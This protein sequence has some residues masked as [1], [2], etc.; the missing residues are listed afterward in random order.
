MTEQ[1]IEGKPDPAATG[2]RLPS[3]RGGLVPAGEG[4]RVRSA[5]LSLDGTYEPPHL[6]VDGEVDMSTLPTFSDALTRVLK[7]SSGDVWVDVEKLGFIDVG[8]LRALAAAA[9]QLGLQGRRLV[10]RSVSPHLA[11]LLV[12]VGWSQ[13]ASLLMLVRDESRSTS[14]RARSTFSPAS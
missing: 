1:T 13:I 8:G 9:C 7:H 6:V 3:S 12:L 5:L 11:R 10:L 2:R 4:V 14:P